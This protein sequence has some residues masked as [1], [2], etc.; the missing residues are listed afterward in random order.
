M[1]FLWFRIDPLAGCDF[2][3]TSGTVQEDGFTHEVSY[4]HNAARAPVMISLPR[5]WTVNA[6]ALSLTLTCVTSRET[7]IRLETSGLA[8]DLPFKDKG[9]EAYQEKSTGVASR[10][11]D[12]R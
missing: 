11:R 7:L 2:R 4:I 6:D 3:V 12:G 5:G 10:W 1:V 9:L 8:P